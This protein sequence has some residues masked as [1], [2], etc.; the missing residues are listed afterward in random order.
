MTD[1]K[2]E[3]SILEKHVTRHQ[4]A[5]TAEPRATN[6]CARELGVREVL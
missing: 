1:D 3:L 2:L 5:E 6:K 4:E